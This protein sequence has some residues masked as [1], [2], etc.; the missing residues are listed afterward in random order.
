M[1][2]FADLQGHAGV[3]EFWETGVSTLRDPIT[4]ELAHEFQVS[5][6][7][8]PIAADHLDTFVNESLKVPARIWQ[9]LF[10]GF[11]D[12]PAFGSALARVTA[13]TRTARGARDVYVPR[14]D[15]DTLQRAIPSARLVV[16]PDGGHAFHWEDPRGFTAD[17]VAFLSE[18]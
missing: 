18:K 5:T 3:Q 10:R 1:G 15:Q 9:A 4:R 8:R 7:A 14:S 17:L 13:P 16:Y 11:L 6:L 12:T 2:A